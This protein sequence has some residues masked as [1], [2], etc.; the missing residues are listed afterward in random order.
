MIAINDAYKLVHPIFDVNPGMCP[1]SVTATLV[2]GTCFS[3][4]N[5]LFLIAKHVHKDASVSEKVC[6]GFVDEE[7][8]RWNTIDVEDY[9]YLDDFDL[10]I[11]KLKGINFPQAIT[12]VDGNCGIMHPVH[13]VG[14]PYG[15]NT[16][17]S[18]II[19]RGFTGHIV[20]MM[21][22][23]KDIGTEIYELD[24]ACPRELSGAPLM[25]RGNLQ[26]GS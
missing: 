20:S 26:W 6:V 24:F 12:M 15:M 7:V 1:A 16:Q 5:G 25:L 10:A 23:E 17:I 11:L 9:E 3:I 13:T 14:Y 19:V 21:P 22:T 18:K 8:K 4:G 2:N